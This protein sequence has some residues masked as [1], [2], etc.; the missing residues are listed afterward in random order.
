[1]KKK[2][3]KTDRKEKLKILK[4]KI[5]SDTYKF[6]KPVNTNI[7]KINSD[8][9]FD[10]NFVP[11]DNLFDPQQINV[12]ADEYDHD[13]FYT[14]QIKLLPTEQQKLIL[15]KWLDA[16]TLMY[17]YTTKYF[18]QCRFNKTKADFSIKKLKSLFSEE[19]DKIAKWSK[20]S[21]KIKKKTKDIYINKHILQY[22][23]NDAINRYK[24]CLTNLKNGNINHFRLRYLK[25]K[26]NNRI[27]KIE[28]LMC[29]EIGFCINALGKMNCERNN[30]NYYENVI[31]V[32]IVKYDSKSDNFYFIYKYKKPDMSQKQQYINKQ[33]VIAID[34][35]IRNMI[36]GYTNKGVLTIGTTT[37]KIIKKKLENI[38]RTFENS[39]YTQK[40]KQK[41]VNKK[42]EKIHNMITDLQWKTVNYL[43][44]NYKTIIIGNFST[45]SMGESNKVTDMTKRI[46]NSY[47]IFKLKQKLK[48]KSKYTNT[49]YKEVDESYTSKCCCYC[50]NLKLNLG[51]DK[52]YVCNKCKKVIGRDIN[53]SINIIIVGS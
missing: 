29:T 45:K 31:T 30:F 12:I 26:K 18:K 9:W 19:K 53:G 11:E 43:T 35:G 34:L 28:R 38:D 46:G 15:L 32:A 3:K 40:E 23:I 49:I 1:M 37:Q 27:M 16:Y 2:K 50:S 6:K 10:I 39:I 4:Q 24:S 33:D 41:R 22:A 47:N 17:N 13:G 7:T 52:I 8:S 42:Y 14:K 36:T 5:K 21:I 44:K 48:Y 51:G 20:V 25:M